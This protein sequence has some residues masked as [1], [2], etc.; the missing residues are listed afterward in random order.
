[1]NKSVKV[2]GKAFYKNFDR[3]DIERYICGYLVDIDYFS[4]SLINKA[5]VKKLL[6]RAELNYG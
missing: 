5:Q 3:N 1:M 2:L 6:D 4:D